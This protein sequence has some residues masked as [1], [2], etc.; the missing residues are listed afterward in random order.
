MAA[1]V[2]DRLRNVGDL[3]D[4]IEAAETPEPDMGDMLVG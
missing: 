1:G 2:S 4:L 3:V